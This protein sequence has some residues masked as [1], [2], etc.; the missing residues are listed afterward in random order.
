MQRKL[1]VFGNLADTHPP[2]YFFGLLTRCLEKKN[3]QLCGR[4]F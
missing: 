4:A 1:P 3:A 2:G